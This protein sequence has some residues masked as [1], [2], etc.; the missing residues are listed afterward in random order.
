V[1]KSI[2]RALIVV[3]VIAGFALTV[4]MCGRD[5]DHWRKTNTGAVEDYTARNAWI[6]YRKEIAKLENAD[7]DASDDK[8]DSAENYRKW[9][10]ARRDLA[11][12]YVDGVPRIPWPKDLMS[13]ASRAVEAYRL[14]VETAK[15]CISSDLTAK[16][17]LALYE[18]FNSRAGGE[19]LWYLHYELDQ[20]VK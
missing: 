20:R 11:E 5:D 4:N 7:A 10:E 8:F 12:E 17:Q 18:E 13:T 16:Q 3:G 1:Q 6:D 15:R 2:Q 9:C 19:A 14:D